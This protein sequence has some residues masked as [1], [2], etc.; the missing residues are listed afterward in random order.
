M[1]QV[2]LLPDIKMEYLR[3]QRN[4]R[5]IIVLSTLLTIVCISAVG[6]MAVF[7]YGSQQQHTKGLQRDINSYM[8]QL[9]EVQDLGDILT[10]QKQ[11][12]TLPLLHEQKPALTKLSGYLEVLV[13]GSI[14]LR[15][16]SLD[17]TLNTISFG[18]AGPTVI[19]VN[20]FA[21]VLKNSYYITT[22]SS[23]KQPVFTGVEFEISVPQDNR[24]AFTAS[25]IFDPAIFNISQ[26]DIVLTVP[27]IVTTQSALRSDSLFDISI[28]EF[29]PE[30]ASP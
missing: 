6:L 12:E 29:Q 27:N 15:E 13:P 9:R 10:V 17:L 19:D 30:E 16:V 18:G 21:D 25:A 3:S 11:L 23:G 1:I 26:Q 2:N 4:K 24:V 8:T 14:K 22:G 20:T 28:P 5:Q 7:V